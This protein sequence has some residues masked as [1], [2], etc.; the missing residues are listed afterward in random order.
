MEIEKLRSMAEAVGATHDAMIE[1]QLRA[2]DTAN[3]LLSTIIEECGVKDAPKPYFKAS[4]FR[5]SMIV[6]LKELRD[7]AT[8]NHETIDAVISIMKGAKW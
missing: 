8:K 3:N 6:N 1:A 2:R 7:K 5:H 4:A